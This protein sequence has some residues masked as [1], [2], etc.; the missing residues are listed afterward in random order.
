VGEAR[1]PHNQIASLCRHMGNFAACGLGKPIFFAARIDNQLPGPGVEITVERRYASKS[2]L[3][4]RGIGE[5]YYA[6]KHSFR[7]VPRIV[8]PMNAARLC[9]ARL[10]GRGEP[11]LIE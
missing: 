9:V 6:L 5:R 8:I 11:A 4:G 3:I 1:I 7:S 10:P 2:T